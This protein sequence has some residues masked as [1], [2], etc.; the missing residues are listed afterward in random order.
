MNTN[1]LVTIILLTLNGKEVTI[2]CI[3]SLK[4]I[5]FPDFKII[6][7]DN[8]SSDDTVAALKN[9]FPDVIIIENE[10]NLGFAGGNNV[11]IKYALTH[12]NPDYLLLLNND[13]IVEKDFL[14]NLIA[15]ME[16]HSDTGAAGSKIYYHN[17]PKIINYAGSYVSCWTCLK[18]KD[19]LRQL[20]D[21]SPR[22]NTVKYV[23]N[24]MGCCFLVKRDV[25]DK[26][27]LLDERLFAYAED[28]EWCLRIAEAGYKLLFVPASIIWHREAFTSKRNRS[29][30]FRLRISTRNLLYVQKWHCK[31]YHKLVFY[32]AF[33]SLWIA[34]L[35]LKNILIGN[36]KNAVSVLQGVND[37]LNGN[38]G[39]INPDDA[40]E[41]KRYV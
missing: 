18:S 32:P 24:I 12:L 6:G 1:P 22:F 16:K 28:V 40:V 29:E 14:T 36:I 20:D 17:T 21:G 5:S 33:F 4:N 2:D 30:A 15:E 25:V 11:G 37:Y 41:N 19:G 39:D 35:M 26:I 23:T 3:Q 7:V 34:P 9:L 31:W 13:T 38:T 10:K 27:G 8:K